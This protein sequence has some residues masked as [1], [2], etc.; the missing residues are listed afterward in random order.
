MRQDQVLRHTQCHLVPSQP[1]LTCSLQEDGCVDVSLVKQVQMLRSARL[2]RLALIAQ[3]LADSLL[4]LS[5][6]TGREGVFVEL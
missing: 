5:D 3:D 1:N 4:A 6:I 2:L